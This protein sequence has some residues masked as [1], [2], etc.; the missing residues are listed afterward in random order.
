LFLISMLLVYVR[1]GM[2]AAVV[3]LFGAVL[4]MPAR[5]GARGA[6][7]VAVAV[8]VGL[9]AVASWHYLRLAA[10]QSA[11]ASGV[12]RINAIGDGFTTMWRH[13]LAGV[14]L[15]R[16][17][18]APLPPAHSALAQAA[19]EMGVLGLVAMLA[20]IGWLC[21]LAVRRRATRWRGLGPGAALAAAAFVIVA[22]PWG[23]FVTVGSTHVGFWAM[24]L[25]LMCGVAYGGGPES[26]SA[27]AEVAP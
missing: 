11:D 5:R 26:A 9:L 18:V 19:A 12:Q 1:V 23:S 16:Y 24:S 2:V 13:P 7:A 20:L 14:G 21:V 15:G 10:S 3:I 27:R 22:A 25:A 4:A 8:G 6:L 17:G